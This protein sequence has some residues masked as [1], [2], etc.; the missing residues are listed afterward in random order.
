MCK[1]DPPI[2]EPMCGHVYP[3]DALTYAEREEEGDEA[4]A[5]DDL[6]AGL[7]RLAE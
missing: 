3:A 1:A 5:Q 4:A 6:D 2:D 7:K